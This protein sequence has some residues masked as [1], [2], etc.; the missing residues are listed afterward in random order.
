[1]FWL[2]MWRPLQDPPK[3]PGLVPNPPN[4]H[5]LSAAVQLAPANP[6]AARPIPHANP[7]T[8]PEGMQLQAVFQWVLRQTVDKLEAINQGIEVFNAGGGRANYDTASKAFLDF[9][10]CLHNQSK[11]DCNGPALNWVSIEPLVAS[12]GIIVGV[13]VV[14]QWLNPTSSSSTVHVP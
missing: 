10:D 4:T 1:M 6:R 7:P 3:I 13:T 8:Q 12:G 11:P 5:R 9:V 2:A 14:A